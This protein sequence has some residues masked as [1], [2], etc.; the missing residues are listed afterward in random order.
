[1]THEIKQ[2]VVQAWAWQKDNRKVVLATV[3]EMEGS[4]YRRPGV[5]MI[6]N[7]L[8]ASFGAVSGGCVEKEV[9]IQAQSVFENGI[10]K[11]MT[12]DGR[13]RLGCEGVIYVLLEPLELSAVLSQSLT[14][15]LEQRSTFC[16]IS[17]FDLEVGSDS[18]YGTQFIFQDQVFSLRKYFSKGEGLR[19]FEQEFPPLFQCCIFGAEH[20]AVILT[21]AAS[22]LGWEVTIIASPDEQKTLAFFPGAKRLLNPTIDQFDTSIIDDQTAIVLMTHSLSKDVQYLLALSD[23]SPC[24]LGLLGPAKRREQ[25]IGHLLE[26]KPEVDLR[27]IELL[28]GP[29]GINIGAENAEEIA[30]SILAE[31]LSVVR[32]QEPIPLSQKKGQI[33]E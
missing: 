24:Y 31:I 12:Y 25:L 5:R 32:N 9:Q 16:S 20:D 8:G 22:A 2:L 33:H 21:K 27:F 17:Y 18:G 3:V 15:A 26:H 14:S 10:P 11:M 30:V 29:S 6:L 28:R 13:L 4:S 1:M 23:T 7:D 19:I